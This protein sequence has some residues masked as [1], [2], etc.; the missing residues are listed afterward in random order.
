MLQM[1]ARNEECYTQSTISRST[2]S[3]M[4]FVATRL[5]DILSSD[6]EVHEVRRQQSSTATP[7]SSAGSTMNIVDSSLRKET[8]GPKTR[9]D[10]IKL[11]KPAASSTALESSLRV[12]HT[13]S[14]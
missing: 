10:T 7:S 3:C 2:R 13:G 9:S 14:V 11:R 1:H 5:S 6:E 12:T 8:V 4:L